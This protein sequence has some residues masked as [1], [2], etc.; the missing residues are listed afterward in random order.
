MT[1]AKKETQWPALPYVSPSV[2]HWLALLQGRY[3]M[4]LNVSME[5]IEARSIFS[6]IQDL[7]V[8]METR[9]AP[10]KFIVVDKAEN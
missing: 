6:A 3:D 10:A 1:I 2:W 4:T 5:D 8:K 9:T 7:G